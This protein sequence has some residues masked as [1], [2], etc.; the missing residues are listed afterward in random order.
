MD[1]G[2]CGIDDDPNWVAASEPG[3]YTASI[4]ARSDAPDVTLRLRLR[5]YAGGSR[6]GTVTETLV[7]DSAWR[8]VS[9]AYT[10]TSPGSTLDLEAY[11]TDAPI[12]VC[13]HAD[14]ASLTH[15]GPAGPP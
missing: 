7:L 13:F 12:G 10:P 11:S 8:Q 1:G 15:E 5:E 14:D 4:W 3:T 2:R 9:V 6:Q